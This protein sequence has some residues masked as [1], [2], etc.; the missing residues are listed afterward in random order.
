VT[1][2]YNKDGFYYITYL[3]IH[4]FTPEIDIY[5]GNLDMPPSSAV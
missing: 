3:P 4:L 1:S 2:E 5:Q